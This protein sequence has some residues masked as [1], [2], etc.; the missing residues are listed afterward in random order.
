MKAVAIEKIQTNQK[1]GATRAFVTFVVRGLRVV[2]AR[3]V[4]GSKG[5]F[6]ALPQK[7]WEDRE[8]QT[9]YVNIVE[10]ADEDLKNEIQNEVLKAWRQ[11]G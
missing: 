8:G 2:N 6:L 3:I 11:Q 4:E 1:S 7:S 10:I 5:A 9:R